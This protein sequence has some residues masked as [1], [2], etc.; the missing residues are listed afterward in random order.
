MNDR[1][2]VG[3]IGVLALHA[4]QSTVA[5]IF[6]KATAKISQSRTARCLKRA[7]IRIRI[8]DIV[9]ECRTGTAGAAHATVK[10][11]DIDLCYAE[12]KFVE[13]GR[14]KCMSVAYSNLSRVANL[15]TRAESRGGQ[16]RK[17]IRAIGLEI[18]STIAT[19]QRVLVTQLVIDLNLVVI[20]P[21]LIITLREKVIVGLIRIEDTYRWLRK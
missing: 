10:D 18:L 7:I 16:A 11:A 1:E 12:A 5:Q 6:S 3:K 17:Q 15:V 2:R 4:E 19:G 8:T 9:S 21:L 14:T 13:H 20:G